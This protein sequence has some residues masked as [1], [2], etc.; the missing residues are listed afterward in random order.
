M[1]GTQHKRCGRCKDVKPITAFEFRT[2]GGR[3]GYCKPCLDA[4]KREYYRKNKDAYVK[5]AL[6]YRRRIKAILQSA[7]DR[8]CAD[9]GHRYPHYV[10]DF[11]HREGENKLCNVSDLNGHR[12]SSLG[13]LRAEIAKCDVVCANCHRERTFQRKQNWPKETRAALK[14]IENLLL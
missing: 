1:D 3:Q 9:C 11:D 2:K 12:R 8:P 14:S 5:R 7:K 10:M 6:C 4:Y 13:K